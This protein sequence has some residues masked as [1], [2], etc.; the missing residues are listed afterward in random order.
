[1]GLRSLGTDSIEMQPK[2]K[3]LVVFCDRPT[4]CSDEAYAHPEV[5]GAAIRDGSTSPYTWGDIER[6]D[7]YDD[8][9]H[10]GAFKLT[11][12]IDSKEKDRDDWPYALR[13]GYET[14]GNSLMT[15]RDVHR[16]GKSIAA[17]ERYLSRTKDE[18]GE[19]SS[20]G[21]LVLRLARALK[22]EAIVLMPSRPWDM[23]TD[24]HLVFRLADKPGEAVWHINN[25]V[26]KARTECA[27][28]MGRVTEDA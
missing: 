15:E 21:V 25:M 2:D 10:I 3:L 27:R 23:S 7:Y 28:L 24:T 4:R 8:K 14:A 11:S 1:M 13:Y 6:H 16:F 19:A 18:H 20:F 5:W 9:M 12:Q 22:V 17:I 26:R